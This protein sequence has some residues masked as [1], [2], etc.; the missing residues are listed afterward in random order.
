MPYSPARSGEDRRSGMDRTGRAGAAGPFDSEDPKAARLE[1]KP[2][3]VDFG[4]LHIAIPAR[5]QL[6]VEKGSNDLLRAVHVLVPAG[7]VSLSALAAPTSNP[8]WRGLA[9]EIAQSLGKDGAEVRVEWGDW[10]REIRAGS[11]GAL[12]RFIGVDGPR[13]M[14]YG[15]ATGPLEGAAELAEELREMV[16]GTVVHRGPDPLPV[17]TVLPLRLP[18][19]LE[20]DVERAR[21]VS[22]RRPKKKRPAASRADTAAAAPAAAI[23]RDDLPADRRPMP[24]RRTVLVPA[25]APGYPAPIAPPAGPLGRP[26]EQPRSSPGELPAV[27]RLS[28]PPAPAYGP[29]RGGGW[30]RPPARSAPAIGPPGSSGRAGMPPVPAYSA[31]STNGTPVL[32]AV[33]ATWSSAS[34]VVSADQLSQQPAWALL[35]DAPVFW[36]DERCAPEGRPAGTYREGGPPPD[37][38]LEPAGSAWSPRPPREEPGLSGEPPVPVQPSSEGGQDLLSSTDALHRVLIHDAAATQDWQ[39]GAD[40]RARHRRPHQP[41]PTD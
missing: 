8:L 22:A 36:P 6:Q 31:T 40:R 24:P 10:G 2:G 30:P 28:P 38:D 5:A 18:E 26:L 16:L 29:G 19:H 32:P 17:K 41:F 12:S 25:P 11:N 27:A 7:R 39:A 33:E 15:V 23:T 13:W 4:S 21:E 20:H 34:P 37:L 35:G 9:D 14:L 3:R 1:R